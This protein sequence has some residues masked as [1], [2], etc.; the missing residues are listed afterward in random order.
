M[1]AEDPVQIARSMEMLLSYRIAG[2]IMT[3]A[4]PPISLATQYLKLEVPVT[5]INREPELPGADVV[6][7]DNAAGGALAAQ[8]LIDAGARRL[9]FVGTARTSYNGKTRYNGFLDALKT[10][11]GISRR[12]VA[13]HFTAIDDYD[14]GAR[15]ARELLAQPEIPDGV[16]CSTDLLALG[17]MDV[18]RHNFN[19]RI[20]E[21]LAV[22]GF[23]DIPAANF[24]SYQLSTIQQDT[25]ALANIAIE[26]LVERMTSFHAHSRV[27]VVPVSC[28][29]RR[30]CS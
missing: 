5:M 1:N 4:T 18:A 13:T 2:A 24:E 27:H 3:S 28:V 17:F 16:F 19:V 6:I 8:M 10:L 23:D 30:S 7:S 26:T 9:A 12:Q 22:V 20:P 15:A 11:S 29:V 21:D 14:S 25:Q